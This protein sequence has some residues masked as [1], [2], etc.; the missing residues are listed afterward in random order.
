MKEWVYSE[1]W[2]FILNWAELGLFFSY[3][4]YKKSGNVVQPFIPFLI[5]VNLKPDSMC[6]GRNSFFFFFFFWN[7]V[8]VLEADKQEC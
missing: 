7:K 1:L 2:C 8:F 3:V 4:K 5:I 6:Y